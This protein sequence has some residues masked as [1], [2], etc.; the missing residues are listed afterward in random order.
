MKYLRNIVNINANN[1]LK[2]MNWFP[3]RDIQRD[4]FSRSQKEGYSIDKM[5]LLFSFTVVLYELI[6][7]LWDYKIRATMRLF[8]FLWEIMCLKYPTRR[9]SFLSG[10]AF[11][12]YD[13]LSRFC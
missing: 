13:C 3:D 2:K 6:G 5:L 10:M 11:S 4:S 9:D 1:N 8:S 7:N 12:I